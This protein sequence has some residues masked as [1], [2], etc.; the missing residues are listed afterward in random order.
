[1]GR[2]NLPV[3]IRVPLDFDHDRVMMGRRAVAGR[4][5]SRPIGMRKQGEGSRLGSD[6]PGE[7]NDEGNLVVAPC[8]PGP[9]FLQQPQHRPP[10]A[11]TASGGERVMDR[12]AAIGTTV[13]KTKRKGWETEGGKRK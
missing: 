10:V 5:A 4:R 11:P 12:A 3:W 7:A 13:R 6:R 9:W 8:R 1:M 2:R